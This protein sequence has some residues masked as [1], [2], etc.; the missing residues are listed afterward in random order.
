MIV[1]VDKTNSEK[2]SKLFKEASAILGV[3][4]PTNENYIKTIQQYFANLK[5][6]LE[7]CETDEEAAKFTILP[8]DE[9]YLEVNANTRKI[10]VPA[11]FKT[12]GVVGDHTA[13]IV[14]FRIDRYFDAVDFGSSSM[15]AT[16]EWRKLSGSKNEGI[17]PAYIKELTLSPNQVLIG[18]P[19]VKE[20]TEENGTLEFALRI[21]Q[22]DLNGNIEYSFSTLPA[23]VNIGNTLNLYSDDEDV[24]VTNYNSLILSRIKATQAATDIWNGEALNKPT[25]NSNIADQVNSIVYLTENSY[26]LDLDPITNQLVLVVDVGAG[27]NANSED[28]IYYSWEHY[29]DT[30][31]TNL[32]PNATKAGEGN[33]LVVKGTGRYRC[34]ATDKVSN[35]VSTG[36]YSQE[37]WVLGAE[38]PIIETDGNG[39]YESA[40]L[41]SEDGVELEIKPGLNGEWY[42][43][44]WDKNNQTN[45]TFTWE[46]T[47]DVVRNEQTDT[48]AIITG[49][50][51]NPYTVTEE[52]RYYGYA[53]ATR[54]LNSKTCLEPKIYR[55]TKPVEIPTN[56]SFIYP[57]GSI[58]YP[59][60]NRGYL[61]Q[62][63][64]L[65]FSATG[66]KFDDIQYQWYKTDGLSDIYEKIEGATGY[67]EGGLIKYKPTAYG[68][69]AVR[70]IASRNGTYSAEGEITEDGVGTLL[71]TLITDTTK[72]SYIT[73]EQVQ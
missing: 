40:I 5:T 17:S 25:F 65:D 18:W 6:I 37:A 43:K 27:N 9:A 11:D 39:K 3:T 45:I 44:T 12:I 53:I 71:P 2:Y 59:E 4:E 22:K 24:E 49:T 13:E 33:Q 58:E 10:T 57:E 32:Q 31:W 34:A 19:I 69:Y 64:A 35:T 41:T 46:K 28:N 48:T 14:F 42:D 51:T 55:V 67:A 66:Y 52:G 62:T 63:I 20:M 15:V 36:A 8:L 72:P 1:R 68:R 70:V 56:N 60:D 47:A 23:Q 54:N 61:G 30:G 50:I 21:Y 26:Y 73:I 7:N 29:T 16:I 38:I